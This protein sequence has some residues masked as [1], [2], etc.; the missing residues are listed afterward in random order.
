MFLEQRISIFEWFLKSVR[1][2][3]AEREAHSEGYVCLVDHALAE[4]E[5]C[6]RQVSERFE[7]DLSRDAGLEVCRVELVPDRD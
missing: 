4:R 2:N 6:V 3:D 1:S 5:V 7:Q